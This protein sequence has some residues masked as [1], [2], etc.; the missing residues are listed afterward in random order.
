MLVFDTFLVRTCVLIPGCR[1]IYPQ[2]RANR[3]GRQDGSLHLLLPAQGRGTA[4]IRG[5]QSR[6]CFLGKNVGLIQDVPS[7]G[8][9]QPV[10]S[11]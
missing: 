11:R 3:Q 7:Q 5:E 8:S 4:S 2:V 1:V 10:G 9:L 6:E